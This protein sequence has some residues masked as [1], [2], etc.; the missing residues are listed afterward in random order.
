MQTRLQSFVESTINVLL[1]WIVALILQLFIFPLYGIHVPISTNIQI[2]IIFT[3]AAILRSY[4][5]RRYFNNKIHNLA[6]KLVH[7][8]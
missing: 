5:I 6:V 4:L 3:I 2:S 1:G 7:D 8:K